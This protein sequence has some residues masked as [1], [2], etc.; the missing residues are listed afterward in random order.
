MNWTTAISA[1]AAYIAPSTLPSRRMPWSASPRERYHIG[2][3]ETEP[4]SCS[5]RYFTA[6]TTSAHFRLMAKKPITTIQKVA[7]G[8]PMAMAIATPAILPSPIVPE[9]AVERAW[10]GD[11]SP[12][13][14]GS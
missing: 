11:I 8:P 14:A 1:K 12:G 10:K 6:S 7:P 2:P 5:E 3:P 4:S 13:A 9:S